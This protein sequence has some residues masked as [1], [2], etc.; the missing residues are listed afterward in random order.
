MARTWT[1]GSG[2]VFGGATVRACWEDVVVTVELE[3]CVAPGGRLA[4][5]RVLR[6][7]HLFADVPRAE[8]PEALR[9][10]GLPKTRM[11]AVFAALYATDRA[12][13]PR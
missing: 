3:Q 8:A 10:L 2:A 5:V 7:G 12:V 1:D 4:S 13:A 6:N 11:G 9:Y